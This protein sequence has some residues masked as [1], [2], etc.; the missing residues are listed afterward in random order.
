MNIIRARELRKNM[1]DAERQ[2]WNHLRNRQLG[3]LKFRRQHPIG[4]YV[5]DFVCFEKKIVIEVD[6]SQHLENRIYDAERTEWLEKQGFKVIR[7]WNND[8]LNEIEAVLEE[9]KRRPTS[10]L[11]EVVSLK[12]KELFKTVSHQRRRNFSRK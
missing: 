10:G 3:G 7:V 12:E 1:T 9:Y 8:V 11:L 6:G 4:K 5:V 2:L